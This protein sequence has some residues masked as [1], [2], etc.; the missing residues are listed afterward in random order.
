M[1]DGMASSKSILV[2]ISLV[3]EIYA[4]FFLLFLLDLI[5]IKLQSLHFTI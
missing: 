2:K 4:D 3:I 1:N 5:I